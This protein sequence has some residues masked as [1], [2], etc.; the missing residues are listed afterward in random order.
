M[1]QAI[2]TNMLSEEREREKK[3]PDWAEQAAMKEMQQL[4]AG[5]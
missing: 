4:F 5:A 2:A 3:N 1:I